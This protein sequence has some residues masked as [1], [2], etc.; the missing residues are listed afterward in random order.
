[1]REAGLGR[2]EVGGEETAAGCGPVP[3]TSESPASSSV[4]RAYL[5]ASRQFCKVPSALSIGPRFS[6]KMAAQ[7]SVSAAATRVPSR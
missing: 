3:T 2:V 1:M 5:N 6:R 7:S 4:I